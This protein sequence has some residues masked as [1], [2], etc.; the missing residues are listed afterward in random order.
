MGTMT[1]CG[2]MM[3]IRTFWYPEDGRAS[4][5]SPRPKSHRMRLTR[6]CGSTEK[7]RKSVL[8]K[9]YRLFPSFTHRESPVFV[10]VFLNL[11]NASFLEHPASEVPPLDHRLERRAWRSSR[12]I[13]FL[14]HVALERFEC[15]TSDEVVPDSTKKHNKK[16]KKDGQSYV[17]AVVNG[18]QE[19]MGGCED[20][21]GGA[22]KW[23]T[24]R[25]FVDGR[26]EKYGDWESVCDV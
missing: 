23:G 15:D 12:L 19:V 17:R 4:R 13:S 16:G 21:P 8:I 6:N 3:T 11:Y 2:K 26:V 5:S 20:G 25:D 24:F 7:A 14:G 9:T 10:A 18:K 22:C 1:T